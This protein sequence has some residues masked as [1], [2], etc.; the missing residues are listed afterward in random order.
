M[1][2]SSVGAQSGNRPSVPKAPSFPAAS[3]ASADTGRMSP[4]HE[5]WSRYTTP[6]MCVAASRNRQQ[7]TDRLADG[8]GFPWYRQWEGDTLPYSIVRDTQSTAAVRASKACAAR[9]SV[10]KVPS[11]EL[12]GLLWLALK[13]Q[14]DGMAQAVVD[15]QVALASDPVARGEVLRDAIEIYL[16]GHP[17]RVELA[18]KTMTQLDALGS[19]AHVPQ[20]RARI[21]LMMYYRYAVSDFDQGVREADH[22]I[23]LTRLLTQE[24]IE[25]GLADWHQPYMEKINMLMFKDDPP[26]V[27]PQAVL[28]SLAIFARQVSPGS[29]IRYLVEGIMGRT[30]FKSLGTPAPTLTGDYV[31]KS[32]VTPPDSAVKIILLLKAPNQW[33]DKDWPYNYQFYAAIRRLHTKYGA[34]LSMKLY[35][36]TIGYTRGSLAQAPAQEAES[37]RQFFQEAQRLPVD[38][39]VAEGPIETKPDGRRSVGPVAYERA[40]P[41]PVLVVDSKGIIQ[42]SGGLYEANYAI[43]RVID[44]LL[45]LRP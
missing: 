29:D 31:F 25:V 6:L 40:F 5:D 42:F 36:K 34:T 8:N 38:V 1:L 26:R 10:A 44:R 30:G 4:A 15:R 27:V 16:N 19:E 21:A 17:P 41:M 12:T 18:Q 43:D 22:A 24:E 33:R 35:D 20:L 32:N 11:N 2:R 45:A 39:I 3:K 13:A 28:D 7:R 14:D 23:V 37:I 9:F